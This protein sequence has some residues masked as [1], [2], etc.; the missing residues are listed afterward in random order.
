MAC[1]ATIVT[2]R[3]SVRWAVM[4]V[5]RCELV[6]RAPA[7]RCFDLARSVDLHADSSADIAARA[8]G[9]RCAGLS[10]DGD[11]T[12]WSARFLGLRFAMQTRIGDFSRP[13]HFRDAMT[14]GLLRQFAHHYQFRP[15]PDGGCVMSDEL[16]VEVP[17]QPLGRLVERL[18]LVGRMKYLVRRRLE[19]IRVV[20]E[21]QDWR[22]YLAA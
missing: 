22:K 10:A 1:Y 12:V 21:G 15:L 18:Y 2:G 5:I 9:G 13:T 4:A 8:V 20:A 7:E 14:R 3:P 19:R 11:T 6:V 17:L 16:R